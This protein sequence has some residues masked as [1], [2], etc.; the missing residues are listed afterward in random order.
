MT[1]EE[2]RHTADTLGNR[3]GAILRALHLREGCDPPRRFCVLDLYDL[4][5][6]EKKK[7]QPLALRKACHRLRDRGLLHPFR[8][9]LGWLRLTDPGRAVAYRLRDRERQREVRLP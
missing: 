6:P 9:D 8:G 5:P 2:V 4:L 7:V 3:Q 1:A